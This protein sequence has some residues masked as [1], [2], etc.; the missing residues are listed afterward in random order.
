MMK[1][2]LTLMCIAAAALSIVGCTAE[3]SEI[4]VMS[5]NIRLSPND[6]FDGEN[7]WV[8]RKSGA[9]AMI[10][11]VKPDIFGIQEGLFHQVNYMEDNLPEYGRYGVGRDDG[12]QRG[13]ANAIFWN[14]E[15]FDLLEKGTY[16]LSETPDTVSRGW[17]GA[18][19]RVVTWVKLSDKSR[20][21]ECVWFFNTHFDHIGKIAREESGKLLIERMKE[22]VPEDEPVFLTGDFNANHDSEILQPIKSFMGMAR[23]EAPVSDSL[24]TFHNWNKIDTDKGGHIIDH[25]FFRG[26]DPVRYVTWTENYGLP[27]ISDH[28]PVYAVFAL[29]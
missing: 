29:N 21:G 9:I 25:I 22:M 16:W 10:E 18:C 26:A 8:F 19:N 6:D 1:R 14:K 17:D 20:G 23:D 24:N 2:L 13:E 7:S 15:R 4:K 3:K 27:C 5:F 11:D 12:Q 28:Y